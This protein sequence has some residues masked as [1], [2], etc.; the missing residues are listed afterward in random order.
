VKGFG[1]KVLPGFYWIYHVGSVMLIKE[2]NAPPFRWKLGR[3]LSIHT[4][5]DGV[6]RVAV[7][8][9]FR[10]AVWYLYPLPFEGNHPVSEFFK[11]AAKSF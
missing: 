5:D 7:D 9:K 11:G 2:D 8:G 10:H 1:G 3:I 6:S 4:G